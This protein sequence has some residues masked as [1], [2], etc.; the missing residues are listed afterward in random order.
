MSGDQPFGRILIILFISS[1]NPISNIRSA[2]SMTKAFR[3]RK[4]NPFVFWNRE[5]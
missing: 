1:S 4:T 2:S 5:G 3:F